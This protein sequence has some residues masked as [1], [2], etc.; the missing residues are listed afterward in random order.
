MKALSLWNPWATLLVSGRKRVE[1]RGWPMHHRG[2]LLIHAAK[3][4]DIHLQAICLDEPFRQCLAEFGVP[5]APHTWTSADMAARKAGWG[6]GFGAVVGRVDV[7]DCYR[8]EQ[9][10][11]GRYDAPPRR[12][13]GLPGHRCLVISGT[14]EAFGDYSAGRFAFLCENP[15][16]F[17]QPIPFRGAQGLFDVPDELLRGAA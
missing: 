2:P 13:S 9:V 11:T 3:K 8:T 5:P 16:R 4:W 14:E 17:A 6:M 1:T 7:V 10:S 12:G 15:V